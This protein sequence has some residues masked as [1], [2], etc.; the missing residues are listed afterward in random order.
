MPF[1]YTEEQ[2]L[3]NLAVAIAGSGEAP[4]VS[5]NS[6]TGSPY[7]NSNLS[8]ALN[9]K[10]DLDVAF[11]TRN[12]LITALP[13][14]DF[15]DLFVLNNGIYHIRSIDTAIALN[16]PSNYQTTNGGFVS[17]KSSY[18]ELL[19]IKVF[20][21]V[22][23]YEV[24]P[25][26]SFNI[27]SRNY[28]YS[29]IPLWG[30]WSSIALDVVLSSETQN[31]LMSKT[32]FSKLLY[33]TSIVDVG[34]LNPDENFT[35]N[36]FA[37]IPKYQNL[38]IYA[39]NTIKTIILPD[40]E[41]DPTKSSFDYTGD[42]WSIQNSSTSSVA[43]NIIA[44]NN[45]EILDGLNGLLTIYTIGPNVKSVFKWEDKNI[46]PNNRTTPVRWVVQ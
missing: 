32:D 41:N 44:S 1:F 26:G 19:S 33:A 10:A 3:S 9:D 31:G 4:V 18:N 6:L 14:L 36:I 27:Y 5:F 42:T 15:N 11:S 16:L 21:Q 23:L 45:R 20:T 17:I 30:S 29:R 40:L 37:S 46:D 34:G 38:M 7:D 39:G 35:N 13:S 2:L 8:T 22:T 28:L 43:I 12:L 25:T 24:K